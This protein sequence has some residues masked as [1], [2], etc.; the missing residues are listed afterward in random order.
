M[1]LEPRSLG[2][3]LH[4]RQW[5]WLK[6]LIICSIVGFVLVLLVPGFG[7]PFVASMAVALPVVGPYLLSRRLHAF[8]ADR[9]LLAKV[10]TLLVVLV[11]LRFA[12]RDFAPLVEAW[13]SDLLR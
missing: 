2:I 8:I 11:Y 10:L 6:A 3:P 5:F 7:I 12:R 4:P 1:E 13:L 9:G